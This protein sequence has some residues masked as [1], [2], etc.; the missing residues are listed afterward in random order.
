[1][2]VRRRERKKKDE[3]KKKEHVE[4]KLSVSGC[5]ARTLI[6]YPPAPSGLVGLRC[7]CDGQVFLIGHFIECRDR[8]VSFD[9]ATR[10][11]VT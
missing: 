8:V 6:L 9:T 7:P 5:S 3:I 11:R 10:T 2:T 4:R 1:M